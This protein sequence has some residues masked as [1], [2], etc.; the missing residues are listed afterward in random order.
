MCEA[1]ITQ[2]VNDNYGRVQNLK[3]VSVKEAKGVTKVT[4]ALTSS[5]YTGPLT[6]EFT[7]SNWQLSGV[8]Q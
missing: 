5:I 3:H 1:S 6:C 7:K 4:V 8:H 2:T